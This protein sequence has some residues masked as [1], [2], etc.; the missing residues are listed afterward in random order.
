MQENVNATN[1]INYA[2][3]NFGENNVEYPS[4][5]SGTVIVRI[6]EMGNGDVLTVSN[7]LQWADVVIKR[8]DKAIAIIFYPRPSY[9]KHESE[10]PFPVD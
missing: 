4:D 10:T 9:L 7:M 5:P 1:V 8:S 6:K 2:V 3:V